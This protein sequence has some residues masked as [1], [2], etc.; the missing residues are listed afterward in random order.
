MWSVKI[1][2]HLNLYEIYFHLKILVQE[3]I[4]EDNLIFSNNLLFKMIPNFYQSGIYFVFW[5]FQAGG[6]PYPTKDLEIL[7]GGTISGRFVWAVP[8]LGCRG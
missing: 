1:M 8:S 6:G 7:C 4:F 2:N 5:V 3:N